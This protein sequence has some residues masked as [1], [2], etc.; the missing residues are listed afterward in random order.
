[1]RE[2]MSYL[3]EN[4]G[5]SPETRTIQEAVQPEM[6]RLQ[7]GGTGCWSSWTP[8]RP[9]GDSGTGKRRWG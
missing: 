2:L 4:Y 7:A 9:A 1:M 5:H 3:P 8:G 6:D